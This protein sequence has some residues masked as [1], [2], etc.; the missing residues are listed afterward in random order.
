MVV[1]LREIELLSTVTVGQ[2]EKRMATS[3]GALS[4]SQFPVFTIYAQKSCLAVKPCE[5]AWCIDRV[6]GHRLQGHARRTMTASSRQH[7]LELCLG[8]RDFL[9][10]AW[11]CAFMRYHAD[12]SRFASVRG[13]DP[14]QGR[15]V[16]GQAEPY[17]MWHSY[18]FSRPP[19]FEETLEKRAPV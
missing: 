17:Q 4:Q 5:R 19:V 12:A 15:E 18:A 16:L 14:R 10:R 3:A 6:Q 2:L 8:E 7:C 11:C 1:S 13:F 9:C